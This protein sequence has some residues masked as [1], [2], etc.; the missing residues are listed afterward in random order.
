MVLAGGMARY[1]ARVTEPVT[2]LIASWAGLRTFAPD[3]V[4]VIGRDPGEP[5]FLWLAGRGGY[6][7]QTAPA[8]SRL[9]ADLVAGRV[10]EPDADTVESLSPKRFS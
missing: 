3:R 1:E 8:A 5:A 2:R 6:G 10:P 4:L 7:F 9:L